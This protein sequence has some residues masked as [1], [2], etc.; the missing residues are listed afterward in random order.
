MSSYER[1]NSSISS[2]YV[3]VCG[4]KRMR[5]RVC[6]TWNIFVKL[7]ADVE[8]RW[9]PTRIMMCF[10]S[11]GMIFSMQPLY[12]GV[13]WC[14]TMVGT[15]K[16][17]IT[18]QWVTLPDFVCMSIELKIHF[19]LMAKSNWKYARHWVIRIELKSYS[20]GE[21]KWAKKEKKRTCMYVRWPDF[22]RYQIPKLHHHRMDTH[23]KHWTQFRSITART[24]YGR[25]NINGQFWYRW[26]KQNQKKIKIEFHCN[27][28]RS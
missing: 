4:N 2:L 8:D 6:W 22:L 11:I 27:T 9:R 23:D 10:N 16:R 14:K 15:N 18:R 12:A 7:I 21:K 1:V 19:D 25:I 13:D 17:K 3:Y 26:I 20:W 28:L 5:V 24:D